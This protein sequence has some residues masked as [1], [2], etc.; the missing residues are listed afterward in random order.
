MKLRTG[1]LIAAL[2]LSS[3]LLVG[4]GDDSDEQKKQADEN[5][6][7]SQESSTSQYAGGTSD[8]DEA[9]STSDNG[10][11]GGEDNQQA[12]AGGGEPVN[13]IFGTGGTGGSYYPIGGALKSVFEESDLVDGVQVVSTGASVQNINNITDGLNQVAIVMSDVAYDAVK[14][15]NQFEGQAAD[16][17]AIAGLYPNVVQVVATA[18]SDIQS[19]A[20]L[21]GKRVGVGKVGSGVEQSAAK[22]LE[23]AGLS[24]DDLAQVSH[25]GYADS[26]TEMSNGNLDAAFFTSGVPNSSITGLMQSTDV[27]FVPVSGDVAST[28]LEKYP[29]YENYEIPAGAPERYDLGDAV[30][31]VAIRN[32]MIV[33]SSMRDDVAEDLAKRFHDYLESGNVSV[34]ALKQFDPATMDKNLVVPVHPGAKAF[35]ETLSSSES[36]ATDGGDVTNAGDDSDLSEETTSMPANEQAATT[37]ADG[38]EA[39]PAKQ[40]SAETPEDNAQPTEGSDTSGGDN[41]QDKEPQS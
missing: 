11:S 28:L 20:D 1:M 10:Q 22:V 21:K 25:T 32:I 7:T 31:T 40:T 9:E 33:P 8:S 26:V 35:Y 37:E 30:N 19:I 41:A 12:A 29:Y 39:D 27:T 24:Y 13:L 16:I 6:Q 2:G 3:T 34:G 38:A 15:Q 4:C 5:Q 36:T 14:G 23:S 17:Q 18:D